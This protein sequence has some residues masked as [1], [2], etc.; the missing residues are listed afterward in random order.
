MN[1]PDYDREDLKITIVTVCR[2]AGDCIRQTVESV[3]NQTFA[4][5]EYLVMDGQSTDGTVEALQSYSGCPF[6][7]IFSGKDSGIYN[8]MNRAVAQASGDYIYFLNAGD[9]LYHNRVVEQTAAHIAE[10]GAADRAIYCG[11]VKMTDP[12]RPDAGRIHDYTDCGEDLGEWIRKGNMPCHQGIFAPAYWLRNHYFREKFRLCAD[13]DWLLYS[14]NHH[15]PCRPLPFVIAEYDLT[16]QSSDMKNAGL[17]AREMDC[18]IRE[19]ETEMRESAVTDQAEERWRTRCGV[20][21]DLSAK[22]LRM[23]L[24]MDRWMMAKQQ[25]KSLERCLRQKGIASVAVYGMGYL[26]ERL[27]DELKNTGIHIRYLIDQKQKAVCSEFPVYDP[28]WKLPGTDAVIVTAVH[29]FDHIK[30][31][32]GRHNAVKIISFED[33][34]TDCLE[35]KENVQPE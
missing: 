15:A 8:A 35:M 11:G 25:G 30:R 14:V 5:I 24:L 7:H 12:L 20:Y 2:N 23:F 29:D 27:K 6:L 32:L 13:Y 31:R 16:G 34:V 33:L 17:L 26:G 28:D 22:H 3:L 10:H 19:A 21:Q 18:V 9:R 1:K 4:D